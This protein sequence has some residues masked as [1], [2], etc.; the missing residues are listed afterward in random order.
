L[1]DGQ[2]FDT[3]FYG[4]LTCYLSCEQNYSLESER[5]VT[6]TSYLSDRLQLVQFGGSVLVFLVRNFLAFSVS[7]III[8]CRFHIYADDLQLYRSS[9]AENF[10]LFIESTRIG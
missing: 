9:Y 6:V 10:Q 3:V 7:R 4:L 2:A 1:E 8:N 5:L